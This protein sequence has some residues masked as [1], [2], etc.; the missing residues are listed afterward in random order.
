M[1]HAVRIRAGKASYSNAYVRTSLFKQEK[2]AGRPMKL[3][4]CLLEV[5]CEK[6]RIAAETL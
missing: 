2:K 3:T 4:V 6:N 1:L 5:F